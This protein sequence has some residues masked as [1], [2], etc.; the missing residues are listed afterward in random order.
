MGLGEVCGL[1]SAV[2][3]NSIFLLANVDI[4]YV[5]GKRVRGGPQKRWLDAVKADCM[6][7]GLHLHEAA[8]QG[9]QL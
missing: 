7:L 9:G 1:V 4:G 8:S 6:Q 5:H 3:V 2:L